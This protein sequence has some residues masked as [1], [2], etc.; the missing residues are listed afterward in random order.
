MTVDLV[1]R[2][3]PARKGPALVGRLEQT[4]ARRRV[5]Q[6]VEVLHQPLNA[7]VD[8]PAERRLFIPFTEYQTRNVV[9]EARAAQA[10][11]RNARMLIRRLEGE[12]AFEQLEN[13]ELFAGDG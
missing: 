13:D 9:Q 7:G 11:E 1:D 3:R 8:K 4:Q 6:F 2:Q 10:M 5:R 12:D